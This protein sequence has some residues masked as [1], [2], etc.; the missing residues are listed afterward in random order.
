[1][2]TLSQFLLLP[3]TLLMLA[4]AP[5][6]LADDTPDPAPRADKTAGKVAKAPL[7]V[8]S[9]AFKSGEAIPTEYTCEAATEKTPPLAWSTVPAGTKSISILMQ[10]LDAPKTAYTH[11]LVTNLPSIETA[12]T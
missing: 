7:V 12:L 2:R 4:A 5:P 6:V 11:W 8:T 10:D 9:T 3:I 1:M